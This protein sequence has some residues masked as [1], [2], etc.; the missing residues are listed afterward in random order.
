MSG[1]ALAVRRTGDAVL[2]MANEPIAFFKLTTRTGTD[3]SVRFGVK[4][5]D[6]YLRRNIRTYS[7]IS[8]EVLSALR[9]MHVLKHNDVSESRLQRR[10]PQALA[11]YISKD[12]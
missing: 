4:R 6:E 5:W 10:D 8:R 3:N 12:G 2:S 9:I 11:P 7:S 1:A